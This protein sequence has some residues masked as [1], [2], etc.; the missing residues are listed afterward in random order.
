M[1]GLFYSK[2]LVKSDHREFDEFR[3]L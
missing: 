1:I 2:L 3:N